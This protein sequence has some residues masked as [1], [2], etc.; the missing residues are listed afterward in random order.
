MRWDVENRN[1]HPCKGHYRCFRQQKRPNREM[2]DKGNRPRRGLHRHQRWARGGSIWVD[3][4]DDARGRSHNNTQIQAE[5]KHWTNQTTQ[6]THPSDGSVV[7]SSLENVVHEP[8][9]TTKKTQHPFSRLDAFAHA[10]ILFAGT[11]PSNGHKSL[12]PRRNDQGQP[13]WMSRQKPLAT[14]PPSGLDYLYSC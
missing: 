10:T 3:Q 5:S 2:A 9:D 6:T 14:L 13:W 11:R 1:H 4:G 7:M 8:M 12:D